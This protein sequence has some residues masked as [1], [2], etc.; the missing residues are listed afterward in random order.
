MTSPIR[1][2][3]FAIACLVYVFASLACSKAG[4]VSAR[5]APTAPPRG[6]APRVDGAPPSADV[7]SLTGVKVSPTLIGRV[8][9]IPTALAAADDGSELLVAEVTGHVRRIGLVERSG[10]V[11]PRLREATVLDLSGSTRF[12]GQNR[13]LLGLA[14]AGDGEVLVACYTALDGAVTVEAFPYTPGSPIDRDRGTVVMSIPH[15]LAGL[16]GGNITTGPDGDVYVAVGDMDLKYSEPPTAQ[17]PTSPLGAVTRVPAGRLSGSDDAEQLVAKGLRNPWGISVDP[18]TGDLWIADV[19]DQRYEEYDRVAGGSG[20]RVANFGWPYFE[21]PVAA[22]GNPPPTATF[23]APTLAREHEYEVCGAV[24][25]LVA[26]GRQLPTLYGAYLYG[27]LCSKSVRAFLHRSGDDREVGALDETVVAFGAG[28]DGAV[29][30][31]GLEGAVYRLDPDGWAPGDLDAPPATTPV[32]EATDAPEGDGGDSASTPPLP[33]CALI[34]VFTRL[35]PLPTLDRIAARAGVVDSLGRLR[36]AEE[37]VEGR[38]RD[39]VVALRRALE[40]LERALA[41]ADWDATDPAVASIIESGL[42]GRPPYEH[43]PD[44]INDIIEAQVGC[45]GRR[46]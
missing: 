4:G 13:G 46:L 30:A 26:R 28:A 33:L 38:T 31:L 41:A 40:D 44:A 21:G 45:P 23:D 14:I 8:A 34:D 6:A 5:R 17:D 1:T 25:G 27:D 32:V 11:V 35:D 37:S 9:A 10:Y 24:G 18:T 39:A 3:A 2:S 29:Y 43:L 22:F 12:D 20:E 16:S 36:A 7:A 19:G 42:V 15:P